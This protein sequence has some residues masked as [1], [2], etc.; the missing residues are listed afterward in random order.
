MK[1]ELAIVIFSK[2]RIE[3]CMKT[4]KKLGISQLT[5]DKIIAVEEHEVDNYKNAL[6]LYN[7]TDWEVIAVNDRDRG[8]CYACNDISTRILIPL[9]FKFML[10]IDDNASIK[11]DDIINLIDDFLTYRKLLNIGLLGAFPSIYKLYSKKWWET[12][13]DIVPSNTASVVTIFDFDWMDKI[14]GFDTSLLVHGETDDPAIRIRQMHGFVGMSTNAIFTK[15]RHELGGQ[16]VA[17]FDRESRVKETYGAMLRK[18]PSIVRDMHINNEGVWEIRMNWKELQE[19]YG[20]G[21]FEPGMN[22]ED[23]MVIFTEKKADL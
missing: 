19:S 11:C 10:K 7:F 8:L 5:Y 18:Y 3:R 13:C 2:E 16:Y 21:L 20:N 15:K 12:G 9:G 6:V 1:D 17:Q 22:I 14:G 23:W 4:I